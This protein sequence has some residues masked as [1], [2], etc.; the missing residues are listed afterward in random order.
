MSLTGFA[1]S[2]NLIENEQDRLAIQNLFPSLSGI[3][4]DVA[5]LV[6]NLRNESLLEIKTTEIT[7]DSS[8]LENNV[9]T[10]VNTPA[11]FA[12]R[13]NVFSNGDK[14]DI[15]HLD[16]KQNTSL[17]TIIKSNSIDKFSLSTDGTT[18]MDLTTL[19]NL[20][21]VLILKR[22]DAVY[23]NNFTYA[24]ISDVDY[25]NINNITDVKLF[26][27]ESVQYP[28]TTLSLLLSDLDLTQRTRLVKYR[29]DG[30]LELD[31]KLQSEGSFTAS[32]DIDSTGEVPGLYITDA[33]SPVDNI[34]AVRAF[35]N[36]N[37]PWIQNGSDL[38]TQA[39]TVTIGNLV[40]NGKIEIDGLSVATEF[41]AIADVFTHKL[42]ITIDGQ[43]YFICL[44]KTN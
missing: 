44:N 22:S 5:L 23:L 39:S 11:E 13:S 10:I 7:A 37:N 20:G 40:F 36:D 15:Y 26:T 27:F 2:N 16:I 28:A 42:P 1:K 12:V 34:V 24:G 30:S 17:L 6:N 25:I 8:V 33:T 41:G 4:N 18:A 21:G 38:E 31:T 9:I 35:S 29:S 19:K 3:S 14:V 32:G 43:T